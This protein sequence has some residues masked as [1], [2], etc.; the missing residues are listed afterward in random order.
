MSQMMSVDELLARVEQRLRTD[1]RTRN[2]LAEAT[3]VRDSFQRLHMFM[4]ETD[5]RRMLAWRLDVGANVATM[6]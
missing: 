5:F 6:E 4:G 2:N 3:E 1:R